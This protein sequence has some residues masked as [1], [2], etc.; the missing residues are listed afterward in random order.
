LDD[1]LQELESASTG[2]SPSADILKMRG[3]IFMRQEKWKE[4]GDALK[5]AMA[6]APDDSDL[7]EWL[8]RADIHLRDYPAAIGILTQ[9][10]K[11]NPQSTDALRDLADAF[12]LH[13]DYAPALVALDQLAR[14]EPPKPGSWFVRGIC[15]DKLSRK[16]EAIEAYQKFLDLDAGQH[17]TQDI[18]AR[19]RMLAL[20]SE[21]GQSRKK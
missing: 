5:Q 11:Q 13:E 17:D 4:A 16:A 6:L 7:A 18:Q 2:A 20:Q 3:E 14:L 8:G 1:A 21:L 10:H 15:Y 19:H 12:F 9:A